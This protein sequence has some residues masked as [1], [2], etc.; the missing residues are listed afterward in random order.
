[1]ER[2]Y[3]HNDNVGGRSGGRIGIR[4]T[5]SPVVYRSGI[6]TMTQEV[7]SGRGRMTQNEN[8][9]P[10]LRIGVFRSDQFG[11]SPKTQ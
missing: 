3:R 10:D 7:M 8:Q 9:K 5:P 1:M 11:D 6:C 2:F 4:Q